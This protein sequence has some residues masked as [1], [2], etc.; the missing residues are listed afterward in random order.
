MLEL[1][2]DR[3][4]GLPTYLQL[5][6]QIEQALRLGM[7]TPGDRLP[8]A[9]EVVA[10]L[11]INP[12]TVHKAYRELER[13]GLVEVRPGQG[14]FVLRGLGSSPGDRNPALRTELER[15]VD[16]AVASG[17]EAADLRALFDVVMRAKVGVQGGET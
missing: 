7:L 15:W 17:M 9:R 6:R 1:Y 5:I 11:A 3:R 13:V 4:S 8:T 2:L 14:T 10:Q 16:T 12:N